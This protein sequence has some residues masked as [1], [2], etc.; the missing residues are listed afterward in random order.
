MEL[1]RA[2]IGCLSPGVRKS[3]SKTAAITL[4]HECSLFV[5]LAVL[6]GLVFVGFPHSQHPE[7]FRTDVWNVLSTLAE[8]SP[9]EHLAGLNC[10]N[11]APQSRTI[12]MI[13]NS[14]HSSYSS[15]LLTAGDVEQTQAL[16]QT[17]LKPANIKDKRKE[18]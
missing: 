8:P 1:W 10:T 7:T 15:M 16:A 2:R 18:I 11:I 14:V 3:T 17:A 5:R 6:F 9:M 13:Y 12:T 4:G